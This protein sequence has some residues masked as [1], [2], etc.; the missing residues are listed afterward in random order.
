MGQTCLS[1]GGTGTCLHTEDGL[2]YPVN[3]PACSGTGTKQICLKCGHTLDGER[4]RVC[5][6][7]YEAMKET[8][9]YC[10]LV[11]FVASFVTLA[12]DLPPFSARVIIRHPVC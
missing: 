10:S 2:S 1:C 3:C 8:L 11:A 5:V 9:I 4:C 6:A 7:R 12:T